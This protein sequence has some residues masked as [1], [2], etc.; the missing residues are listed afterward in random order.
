MTAQIAHIAYTAD[1]IDI[2]RQ[3]GAAEVKEQGGARLRRTSGR[4]GPFLPFSSVHD[5]RISVAAVGATPSFVGI[6]A[7]DD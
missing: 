1:Q 6:V 4:R 2:M 5:R 3:N 7:A